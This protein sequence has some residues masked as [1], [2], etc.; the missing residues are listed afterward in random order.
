MG[1]SEDI[2]Y[3]FAM[4]DL[5]T[6]FP[7]YEG[8]K[9]KETSS[10]KVSEKIFTFSRRLQGRPEQAMIMISF[11]R[12]SDETDINSF[13]NLC[14]K[15]PNCT[16]KLLLVPGFS[17]LPARPGIMEVKEMNAFGYHEGKLVWLTKKKNAVS[18]SVPTQVNS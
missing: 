16:R 9:G 6:I 11:N 1:Y 15:T 4:K 14:E 2:M 7:E 18:P 3:D 13:I 17:D 5:K 10:T 8:W 12:D